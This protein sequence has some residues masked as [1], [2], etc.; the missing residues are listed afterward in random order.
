M[1]KAATQKK[2]TPDEHILDLIDK[3]HD[4]RQIC[5]KCGFQW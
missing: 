4:A 3:R 1:K 2:R 5:E